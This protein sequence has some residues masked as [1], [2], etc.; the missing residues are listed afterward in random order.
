MLEMFEKNESTGMAFNAHGLPSISTMSNVLKTKWSAVEYCFEEGILTMPKVCPKCGGLIG[1]KKNPYVTNVKYEKNMCNKPA[2]LEKACFTYRCHDRKCNYQASIFKDSF[3]NNSKKPVNEILM[4]MLFWLAGCSMKVLTMFT[5]WSEKCALMYCAEFRKLV[6]F[7]MADFIYNIEW[8]DC[9]TYDEC[10]IGG[11]GIEVQIDES[12]FGRRKYGRGHKVDT[13]WVF[14]GVEI[15]PDAT[16]KKKGGKYFAVVVPDRQLNTLYPIMLKFIRPGTLI[17]A[18]SFSVYASLKETDTVFEWNLVNHSKNY[19]DP[20]SGAC[21]NT[22]EGKWNGIKKNVPRQGFR[23]DKVL[24]DY[25]G[26]QMWRHS[27]KGHL[28]EAAIIALKFY[29]NRKD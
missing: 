6:S 14:G 29:V 17:T 25:L 8:D 9:V 20:A 5:G 19:V 18:D 16:W 10:L 3:F 23:D 7:F 2:S 21:T 27:N 11:P 13:K 4:F 26:E 24:Q 12:A 22:I 1:F 15:V 28:W